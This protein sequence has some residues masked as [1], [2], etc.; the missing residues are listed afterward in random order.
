MKV[1]I[2]MSNNNDVALSER[3]VLKAKVEHSYSSLT[4]INPLMTSISLAQCR[5]DVL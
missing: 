3:D 4:F 5:G 1:E 2:A